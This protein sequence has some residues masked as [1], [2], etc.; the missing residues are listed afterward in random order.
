[1]SKRK[2]KYLDRYTCEFDFI[3]NVLTSLYIEGKIGDYIMTHTFEWKKLLPKY[4]FGYD[5]GIRNIRVEKSEKE[6]KRSK[7]LI[8]FPKP[9]VTP[10][11]FY[12]LL[13]IGK[14]SY[15]YYTLE[16]DLG[17]S[18]VFKDGGGIICGQQ[19]TCHLNYGRRCKE[20]L[21]EFE[22]AVQDIIDGKPYDDSENFKNIDYKAAAKEL[23]MQEDQFKEKYCNI[24]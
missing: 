12:A 11:C 9:K 10:E 16:L 5:F 6:T 18:I 1:M 2:Y 20:D 3:P 14:N 13:Y 21:G 15:N 17:S 22:Q 24:Y 8:T 4:G 19:G 7:F 23:G